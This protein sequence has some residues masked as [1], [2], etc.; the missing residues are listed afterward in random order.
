M[1]KNFI[2]IKKNN[3]LV[4]YYLSFIP[5]IIYGLYKNGYLLF[6]NNFVTAASAYKIAL[7]PVVCIL[8]GV[9]FS[10]I[11]KKRRRQVV[12]FALLMGMLAPYNFNMHLYFLIVFLGLFMA[13]FVP[14]KYKINEVALVVTA[15]IVFNN[16]SS[17]FNVFNPM[18]LSNTYNYSLLDLFFGRRASYLFTSSIFF[19]LISYIILS[20]VKTYKR[21][22]PFI[23]ITVFV[24]LTIA[25]MAITGNYLNN[26]KVLLNGTTFFSFI[27][28]A[29]QNESSP[30]TKLITYIYASLIAI[31]SFI[32]I[33]ILKVTSG[34]IIAVLIVSI[35]YRIYAIVRQK[36]LLKQL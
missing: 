17:S 6:K 9:I 14:N 31:V 16:F 13:A 3:D 10:L 4:L 27:Y 30:S 18:E 2:F 24:L 26:I 32:F 33:Y 25:Y 8:M 36:R 35:L 5:L 7:Y 22:I 19:T 20:F 1:N 34:S 28:L 11:F 29:T 21:D 12:S 23:E 15:L